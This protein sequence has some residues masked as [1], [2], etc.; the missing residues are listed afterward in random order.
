MKQNLNTKHPALAAEWHPTKNGDVKPEDFT[1]GSG[2]KVWWKCP[3]GG[4]H[5]WEA[6]IVERKNGTGCSICAGK[7][8]VKSNSLKT[9]DPKLAK[10]WHPTK[11]DPMRPEDVTYGSGKMVWWLCPEGHEWESRITDRTTV[12]SRFKGICPMCFDSK[13]A[14]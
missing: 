2:K 10:E 1:L 5:E 9:L 7:K 6:A 13:Q 12:T 4:D 11:N 8:I 14:N 3:K